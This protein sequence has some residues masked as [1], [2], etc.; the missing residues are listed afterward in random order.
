[1]NHTAGSA[2]AKLSAWQLAHGELVALEQALGEAMVEYAGSRGEPPRQL[3]IQV[4]RKREAVARLFDV[5]IEALDAQSAARTG[6][7]YFG[8]LPG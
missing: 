2:P 7:T 4:E 8:S 1:M 5:A 3:I 6:L